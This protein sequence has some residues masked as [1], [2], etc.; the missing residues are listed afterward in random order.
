M[1]TTAKTATKD[2]LLRPNVRPIRAAI[3][4]TGFIADYHALGIRKTEGVELVSVCDP[5]IQS[6]HAFAAKWHVPA[7]FDSIE[8]MLKQERLD[9]STSSPRPTSIIH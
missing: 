6:A 3:V 1:D 2:V 8:S 7:V 5:N 4:G 9:L